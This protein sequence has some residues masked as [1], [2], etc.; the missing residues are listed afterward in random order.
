MCII[1]VMY[2]LRGGGMDS[3]NIDCDEVEIHCKYCRANLSRFFDGTVTYQSPDGGC[4]DDGGEGGYAAEIIMGY[5][6]D[7]IKACY[8]KK[9]YLERNGISSDSVYYKEVGESTSSNS[10]QRFRLVRNP[11]GTFDED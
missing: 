2:K 7:H 8:L 5:F 4:I 6:N 3:Y 1:K 10:S 11:D 9:E